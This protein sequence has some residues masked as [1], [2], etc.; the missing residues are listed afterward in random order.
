MR[1]SSLVFE[2]GKLVAILYRYL[3]SFLLSLKSLWIGLHVSIFSSASWKDS[4]TSSELVVAA[5]VVAATAPPDVKEEEALGTWYSLTDA[6][7]EVV[8]AFVEVVA[9]TGAGPR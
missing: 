1:L 5:T 7:V 6:C 3:F 4:A 2:H 9:W 8:E